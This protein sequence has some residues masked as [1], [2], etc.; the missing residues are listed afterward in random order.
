MLILF[1]L[2]PEFNTFSSFFIDLYF[3]LSM[4]SWIETN[5]LD[6]AVIVSSVSAPT[7]RVRLLRPMTIELTA[8]R[9]RSLSLSVLPLSI[10]S[11]ILANKLAILIFLSYRKVDLP[12]LISPF[13]VSR[14]LLGFITL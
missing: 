4:N 8:L 10:L 11:L 2:Y 9:S 7:S 5:R 1:K 14:I 13:Y 6:S 12:I 3:V